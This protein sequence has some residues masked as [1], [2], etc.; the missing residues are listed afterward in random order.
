VAHCG[1]SAAGDVVYTLTAVDIATGWTECV[2][3]PNKRQL[4]VRAALQDLRRLVPFSI[5]GIDCDNGSEFLN[6]TCS[7]TVAFSGYEKYVCAAFVPPFIA[8]L[9]LE[10]LG[11]PSA[12]ASP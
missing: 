12:S 3:M 7:P 8:R 6:E 1:D 5:R 2:A 4:T 10:P 11:L 9:L